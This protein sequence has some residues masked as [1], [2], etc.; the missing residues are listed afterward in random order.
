MGRKLNRVG[1]IEVEGNKATLLFAADV[2]QRTICCAAKAL[3][4]DS[5]NI[6]AVLDE[7]LPTAAA[8]I[9]VEFDFH[10]KAST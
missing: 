6:E 3:T 2:D 9:F 7:K 8:E 1:E 10:A 5:F 4:Q